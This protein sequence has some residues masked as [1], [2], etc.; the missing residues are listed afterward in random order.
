MMS[1]LGSRN[2]GADETQQ[3]FFAFSAHLHNRG[4]AAKNPSSKLK[5]HHSQQPMKFV[6][7]ISAHEQE[8][9]KRYK[10]GL[11]ATAPKTGISSNPL[12]YN[13]FREWIGHLMGTDRQGYWTE[14]AFFKASTTYLARLPSRMAS[15]SGFWFQ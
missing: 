3:C 10:W 7:P 2:D 1:V 14:I 6:A 11:C 15:Y 13:D 12:A 4:C 9:G 5:R 8:P